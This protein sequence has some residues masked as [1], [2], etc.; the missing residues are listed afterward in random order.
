VTGS[1]HIGQYRKSPGRIS[2]QDVHNVFFASIPLASIVTPYS[3]RY[4]AYMQ[5]AIHVLNLPVALNPSFKAR[6]RLG[7]IT[8]P[9]SY[10]SLSVAMRPIA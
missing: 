4:A 10:A 9:R 3:L 7:T 8:T 6:P 1:P 2:L 5:S